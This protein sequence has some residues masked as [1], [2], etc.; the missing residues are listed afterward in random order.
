[1]NPAVCPPL[2]GAWGEVGSA[3]VT[4]PWT[5]GEGATRALPWL[6]YDPFRLLPRRPGSWVVSESLRARRAA[7]RGGLRGPFSLFW[8]PAWGAVRGP[9]CDP[10]RGAYARLGHSAKDPTRSWISTS[11]G[12]FVVSFHLGFKILSKLESSGLQRKGKQVQLPT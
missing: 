4:Q 3:P 10:E 8:A 12:F 5:S 1:L 9:P 7:G 2:S 11:W 6:F